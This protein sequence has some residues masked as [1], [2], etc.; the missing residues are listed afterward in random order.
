M[1][2]DSPPQSFVG[3]SGEPRGASAASEIFRE[4]YGN[5][6]APKTAQFIPKDP[7]TTLW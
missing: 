2:H 6:G 7:K 4:E 3:D 1:S 5:I